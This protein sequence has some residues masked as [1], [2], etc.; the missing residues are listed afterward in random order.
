M[1]I[2]VALSEV[3]KL[4][5]IEK[6]KIGIFLKKVNVILWSIDNISDNLSTYLKFL[7]I[8]LFGTIY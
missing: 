5:L 4:I 1:Y 3:D 6:R 8:E 2:Y 7:L